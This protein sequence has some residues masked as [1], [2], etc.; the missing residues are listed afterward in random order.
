MPF[1][2]V[3]YEPKFYYSPMEKTTC[4]FTPQ[5][6]IEDNE[7]TVNGVVFGFDTQYIGH[8]SELAHTC[9]YFAYDKTTKAMFATKPYRTIG[10]Q[11]YEVVWFNKQD[12]YSCKYRSIRNHTLDVLIYPKSLPKSP[13]THSWVIWIGDIA[14]LM[15][16]SIHCTWQTDTDLSYM[17]T[18][19][20]YSNTNRVIVGI[21]EISENMQSRSQTFYKSTCSYITP[22]SQPH[23]RIMYV[24]KF[25]ASGTNFY[26]VLI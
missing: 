9:N 5:Q 23:S 13:L 19:E 17:K 14:F 16:A 7:V 10:D 20:R 2:I 15:N 26:R 3:A 1:K 8:L 11:A 18:L 24:G 6:K 12:I 4:N 21:V 22:C 25:H